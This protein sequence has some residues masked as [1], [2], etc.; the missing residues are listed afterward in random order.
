M[1]GNTPLV[2]IVEDD[3]AHLELLTHSVRVQGFDVISAED[4]QD[5]LEMVADYEPDI[6][7]LDWMLPT[8]SGP[9]VC[10]CIRRS[11]GSRFT[12]VLLVSARGDEADRVHGLNAGAD[13]YIVKPFSVSELVA[14]LRANLRRVRPSAVGQRME[15]ADIV[16]DSERHRV[17]RDNR[18]IKV[19]PTEFRLLAALIERP[20]RVWSRNQLL[21]RVWSRDVYVDERT[22]DVHVGRLRKALRAHGGSDPIRTVRGVGYSLE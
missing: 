7:L 1:T 11:K 15:H 5:A 18:K 8:L 16:V 4:G 6:V 2:L 3:P 20:G 9:E 10:R 14:R 17:F 19:G 13:D 22:V 12:P 21:D